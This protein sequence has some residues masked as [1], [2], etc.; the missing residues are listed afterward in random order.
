VAEEGIEEVGEIFFGRFN[1]GDVLGLKCLELIDNRWHRVY[2][3]EEVEESLWGL[4]R[5]SEY[6]SSL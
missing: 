1:S 6:S 4:G 3:M 2:L 5:I